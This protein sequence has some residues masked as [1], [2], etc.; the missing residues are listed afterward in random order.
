MHIFRL[1]FHRRPI[2][3]VSLRRIPPPRKMRR[4]SS[5]APPRFKLF[6]Q[7]NLSAYTTIKR[8]NLFYLGLIIDKFV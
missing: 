1:Y 8:E 4:A 5:P 6:R 7:D 3:D 2:K